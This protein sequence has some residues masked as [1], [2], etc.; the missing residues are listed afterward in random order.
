MTAE[1]L[2]FEFCAMVFLTFVV[3]DRFIF[4][5]LFVQLCLNSVFVQIS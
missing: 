5:S 3:F 2:R 1:L 4:S